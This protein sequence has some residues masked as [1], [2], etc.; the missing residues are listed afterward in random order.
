MLMRVFMSSGDMIADRRFDFARDLQVQRRSGRGGGSAAAD[1]R[2]GARLR[3]R[4]VH[5]RRTARAAAASA[6]GAIEAFRRA[7]ACDPEDRHGAGL[8]LT[9]LG[10]AAA[11]ADAAGLSARAVRPIRAALRSRA[12]RRPRLSRAGAV[13]RGGAVGARRGGPA[14]AVS[15][16]ASISAAAPGSPRAPSRRRSTRSSASIC[17]R[18]WPNWPAPPGFIATSLWR[19]LVTGLTQQSD[20]G[21]DL[22]LAADVLIYLHDPA[23]AVRRSRAGAGAG[24]AVGL[25]RRDP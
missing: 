20:A 24:R 25:H 4:L 16:R 14:G 8:R 3:Q 10:A 12:G 1:D 22:I 23:A 15:P 2:T 11:V 7:Q 19:T 21:F 5:G 17:R 9:R 18:G 13:A 6:T